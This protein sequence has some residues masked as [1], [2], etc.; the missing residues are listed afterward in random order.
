M[1]LSSPLGVPLGIGAFT[2][3]VLPLQSNI[4]KNNLNKINVIHLID[5]YLFKEFSI[6]KFSK[7]N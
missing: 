3:V 1:K 6:P 7:K 4:L 2:G 5:L